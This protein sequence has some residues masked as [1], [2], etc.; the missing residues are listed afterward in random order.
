MFDTE[1]KF[2]DIFAASSGSGLFENPFAVVR[3]P[4]DL[5]EF[6]SKLLIGNVDDSRV[7]AYDPETYQFLVFLSRWKADRGP[8]AVGA[9]SSRRNE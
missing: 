5:G 2:L 9:G 7:N 3:A 6:S 8:G 4:E 1:G